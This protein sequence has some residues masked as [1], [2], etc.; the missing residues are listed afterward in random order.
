MLQTVRSS[1]RETSEVLEMD[2]ATAG[3]DSHLVLVRFRLNHLF[4]GAVQAVVA[5]LVVLVILVM[6]AGLGRLLI[7]VVRVFS[8]QP[9]GRALDNVVGDILGLLVVIELF[10]SFIEY[11]E[12]QRL[13]VHSLLSA[14]LV[15][16]VRELILT[17]YGEHV[18]DPLKLVG[19]GVAILSLGAVRAL[20]IRY[21]PESVAREPAARLEAL[22][23]PP[24]SAT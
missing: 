10:R 19:F 12:C 15:F 3:K 17:I 24:P 21:S 14:A 1:Y 7:S 11:Q 13:R 8:A 4:L 9:L 16:V 2:M 6:F 20:A 23:E 22:R 5:V 18:T